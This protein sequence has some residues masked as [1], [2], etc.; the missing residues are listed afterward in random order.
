MLSHL[1]ANSPLRFRS[2]FASRWLAATAPPLDQRPSLSLDPRGSVHHGVGGHDGDRREAES[3][4]EKDQLD[5]DHGLCLRRLGPI[6]L[7]L[8]HLTDP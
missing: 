7:S 3:D 1:A 5:F 8:C 4:Q 2:A 6:F